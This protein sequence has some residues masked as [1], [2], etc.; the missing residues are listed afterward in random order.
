M[1][2]CTSG[3]CDCQPLFVL[4]ASLGDSLPVNTS[5]AF[6][7]HVDAQASSVLQFIVD[8]FSA[9]PRKRLP[10]VLSDNESGT[11]SV[12]QVQMSNF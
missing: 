3:R 2:A 5:P 8:V 12:L 7:P 6:S 9:L 11:S 4:A 1:A 10:E